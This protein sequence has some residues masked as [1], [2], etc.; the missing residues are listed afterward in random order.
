MGELDGKLLS[1][2]IVA[3]PIPSSIP[4]SAKTTSP[5]TTEA[6]VNPA[7]ETSSPPQHR[8]KHPRT[9]ALAR[10]GPNP[11][12]GATSNARSSHTTHQGIPY[13]TL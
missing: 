12:A 6:A 5:I 4:V 10:V 13:P 3:A 2:A 11:L 1:P 7:S 9:A 8:G